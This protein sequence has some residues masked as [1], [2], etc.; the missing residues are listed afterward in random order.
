MGGKAWVCGGRAEEV[1]SDHGL[2]N[3][4]VPFLGGKVGV[5]RGKYGAK[6]IFECSDRTFG[7]IVA[8]GVRGNKVEVN[9]VLAEGFLHGAGAL[10]V[11]DLDSGGCTVL[12]WVFMVCFPGCSDL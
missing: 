3:E 7:G 1:E 2:G 10:V 11:E 4:T 5:A 8:V 12:L 6:M 9:I